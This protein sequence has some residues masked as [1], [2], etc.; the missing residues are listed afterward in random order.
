MLTTTIKF[1]SLLNRKQTFSTKM[2]FTVTFKL[3]TKFIQVLT[4]RRKTWSILK[5]RDRNTFFICFISTFLTLIF[6]IKFIL[7]DKKWIFW[8]SASSESWSIKL[9]TKNGQ[10]IL[11]FSQTEIFKKSILF[12]IFLE[13]LWTKYESSPK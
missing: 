4:W 11:K 10:I 2:F 7:F 6:G 8:K 13:I 12:G 3:Q 9:T 5:K 1:I